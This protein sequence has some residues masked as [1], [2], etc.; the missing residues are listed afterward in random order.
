MPVDSGF[1]VLVDVFLVVGIIGLATWSIRNMV[2]ARRGKREYLEEINRLKEELRINKE[3]L[4]KTKEHYEERLK[5][6]ARIAKPA[7]AI[8]EALEAGVV[9]LVDVSDEGRVIPLPDGTL[10]C[11]KRHVVWPRQEEQR[12]ESDGQRE[13]GLAPS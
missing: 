11:E 8:A 2:E 4:E 1:W 6:L 12:G 5:Q 10:V 13:P 3:L 7:K 9:K